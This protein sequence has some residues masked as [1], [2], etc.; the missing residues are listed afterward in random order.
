MN[1]KS[2]TFHSATNLI[3]HGPT[4]ANAPLH[5][6]PNPADEKISIAIA[7]DCIAEIYNLQGQLCKSA[8]SHPIQLQLM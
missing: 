8:I 1:F 7:N 2:F 5:I 4:S 3:D 6:Y